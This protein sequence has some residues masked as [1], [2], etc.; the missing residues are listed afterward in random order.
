MKGQL[1][2]GSDNK[3]WRRS[4]ERKTENSWREVASQAVGLRAK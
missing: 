1:D 3:H 4:T 2:E